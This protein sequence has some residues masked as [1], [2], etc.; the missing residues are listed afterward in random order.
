[1]TADGDGD[2]VAS[3]ADA[4][5]AARR[6]AQPIEP[7]PGLSAADGSEVAARL[8]ERLRRDGADQI[9]WKI[10]A[11]DPAIQR[12][13][14]TDRPFS[15]PVFDT[16]VVAADSVISLRS[17]IAPLFETEVGVLLADGSAMVLPCIEIADCRVRDWSV[18][19]PVAVADFG[20]QG[21]ML[22]GRSIMPPA[23]D[24]VE[25][26]VTRDGVV[27]SRGPV[28]VSAAVARAL[29]LAPAAASGRSALVATGAVFAPVP[30][31]VGRW[32]ISLGA[33]GSLSLVVTA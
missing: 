15:A 17:L 2:T 1:M 14:G 31:S 5:W 27:V 18:T 4:L 12:R 25:A 26:V 19:L 11:T 20:L 9:G 30:L 21:A 22:F 33:V 10:A 32:T 7:I 8:Y 23:D 6:S 29:D 13:F 28:D 24:P 3:R 16:S